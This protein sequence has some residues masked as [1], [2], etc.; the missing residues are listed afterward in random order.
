MGA[1]ERIRWAVQ[2]LDVGPDDHVLEFGCGP[3][4][5]VELVCARLGTGSITAVDRSATAVHR[6]AAR[7][8]A[9]VAA[10]RARVVQG[11]LTIAATL[12]RHYD[13]IFAV[14]VNLFWTGVA[15]PE[16]A[17]LASLLK[18]GAPLRLF[19]ET[20][21]PD[22]TAAIARSVA[23]SLSTAGFTTATLKGPSP[24]LLCVT[25]SLP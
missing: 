5:A 19:Y 3:G 1:P 18:P 9:H 25:G 21:S 11:D 23:A 22:R 10:G 14:N 17:V 6:T 15:G 2:V 12:G 16:L 24:A 7:N 20:P 13:K 4:V 8:A